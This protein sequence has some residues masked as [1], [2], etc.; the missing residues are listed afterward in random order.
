MVGRSFLK[1][2]DDIPENVSATRHQ[3]E[4]PILSNL[5]LLPSWDAVDNLFQHTLDVLAGITMG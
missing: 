3:L 5:N 2:C 4:R 1:R